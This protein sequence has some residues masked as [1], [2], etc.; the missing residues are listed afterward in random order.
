MNIKFYQETRRFL[1]LSQAFSGFD[2]HRLHHQKAAQERRFLG[3]FFG[4]D[5]TFDHTR[6]CLDGFADSGYRLLFFWIFGPFPSRAVKSTQQH[7]PQSKKSAGS[8][9][10]HSFCLHVRKIQLVW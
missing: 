1:L 8:S 7:I 10:P 3:C 5:H 9:D 2:S 6:L 4:F